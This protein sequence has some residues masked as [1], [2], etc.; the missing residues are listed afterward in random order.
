MDC[1][2]TII[3]QQNSFIDRYTNHSEEILN[4][5]EYKPGSQNDFEQRARTEAN[6][7]ESEL[8]D[9]I[10]SYMSD[11]DLT[12][13]QKDH[14]EQI[15]G[16]HKVVIGGQQAG[17]FTGPLYTF[18][19]MVSI[20][21]L[22]KEQSEKLNT[23]IVPVFWIAGEDHDFDEV[24]H[25]YV[26]DR[27]SRQLNKVKYSTMEPPEKSVSQYS[28]DKDLI[29]NALNELFRH[30][31]ETS[32]S[33]DV[34]HMVNK[35]IE[36]SESWSDIF[37]HIT[38]DVFKEQGLLLIDASYSKLRKLEV[39]MFKKMIEHSAQVDE[40]FRKTQDDFSKVI[41]KRMIL[42]DSNVHL[43]YDYNE[44]R[45]LLMFEDNEFY[46]SKDTDVRFTKDELLSLV[47]TYPE[48]F[49]NNVVTRPVMEEY[50]FNTLS[51]VG[52]PS[53]IIYWGE[54]KEVFNTLD[55]EMPIVIPRMRISYLTQESKKC[56]EKYNID[57]DHV[58]INGV[59]Q[60]KERFIREKASDDVLRE[61]E[62]MKDS[63]KSFHQ[64][65]IEE[66]GDGYQN[67]KLIEKNNQIHQHQYQYLIDRYL[68][69]VERE[70]EISM[71]HFEI[72][73]HT[74]HPHHGLQERVWNPVQLL[75]QFGMSMFSPS[76]YPPLSYTFEHITIEL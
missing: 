3:D 15:R 59:A 17:L 8:A 31:G 70:N 38:H 61:I 55:I 40:S 6:G 21:V 44:K 65:L 36:T 71:R 62:E 48:R 20:I 75:N 4:F 67:R 51:F 14:L 58:L 25:T 43:F 60:D 19:K 7:R 35:A 9:V 50:L 54:L 16:G 29:I 37:K 73:E 34:R 2:K 11:L 64:R 1:K 5:Y 27:I 23:P 30:I 41:N 57:L 39:P 42:T 22:A 13:T 56:L 24:N 32:H 69:N 12:E 47:E 68:L 74:L 76:T 66:I 33:K 28:F 52:G 45:Q 53:E 63:Q 46:L 72:V 18:H 26:Y 10:E 49:S